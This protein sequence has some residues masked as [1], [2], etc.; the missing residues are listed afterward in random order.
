MISFGSLVQT[1]ADRVR[2]DRVTRKMVA[3]L[4]GQ[5]T[6]EKINPNLLK[7]PRGIDQPTE[8][9]ILLREQ[10]GKGNI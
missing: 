5:L 10:R 1:P 7:M 3:D 2:A 8:D 6:G 9:E 4:L